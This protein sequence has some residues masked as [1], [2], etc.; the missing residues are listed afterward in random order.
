MRKFVV[1]SIATL[2]VA[3]S[4]FAESF[5]T[6]KYMLEHRTYN[7][8]ATYENMG[9]YEGVVYAVAEYANTTY[10]CERGEYLPHG[11]E[12]CETCPEDAYCPGGQYTYNE[13]SDDGIE[14]CGAG[15]HA[16]AGMWESAQCGHVLHVGEDVVYLRSTPGTERALAFKFDDGIFYANMS[17]S[18]V[19]MHVGTTKQLKAGNGQMSW[20]IYD[21]TAPVDGN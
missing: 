15:L 16:P 17:T 18:D 10:D 21:D 9:V 19:P 20:S 13:E 12:G 4:A 7:N 5:P 14:Y 11:T 8:A 6:D 1:T 3:C 2:F